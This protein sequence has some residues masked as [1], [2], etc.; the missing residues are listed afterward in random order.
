MCE[1]AFRVT[2]LSETF[3][4][5][6]TRVQRYNIVFCSSGVVNGT[7]VTDFGKLVS[8]C[9]ATRCRNLDGNCTK[10]HARKPDL[11][12]YFLIACNAEFWPVQNLHVSRTNSIAEFEVF[13]VCVCC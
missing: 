4:G 13:V 2:L 3:C 11:T 8:V 5:A 6:N 9:Q 7:N 10:L 12:K 1:L